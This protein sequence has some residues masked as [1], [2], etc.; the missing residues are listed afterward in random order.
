MRYG[1]S[2][3]KKAG[4]TYLYVQFIVY[5][6]LNIVLLYIYYYL[7][8]FFHICNPAL[9]GALKLKNKTPHTGQTIQEERVA[10]I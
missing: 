6:V 7:M 1:A 9:R 4:T 3:E 10:H 8:C 5:I 2:L